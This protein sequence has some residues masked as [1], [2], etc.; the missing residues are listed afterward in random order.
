MV[1]HEVPAFLAV[2]ENPGTQEPGD[3]V[4]NPAEWRS[5]FPIM[6]RTEKRDDFLCDT[7]SPFPLTRSGVQIDANGITFPGLYAPISQW[8]FSGKAFDFSAME[9]FL[10][11]TRSISIASGVK[12]LIR[13]DPKSLDQLVRS[14]QWYPMT[15]ADRVSYEYDLFR[16]RYR[17][18][19][20]IVRYENEGTWLSLAFK[21]FK[22]EIILD[23]AIMRRFLDRKK[24]YT[25]KPLLDLVVHPTG[26]AHMSNRPLSA[27]L[28]SGQQA[29]LQMDIGPEIIPDNDVK[30]QLEEC[31]AWYGLVTHQSRKVLKSPKF[32]EDV[33][34]YSTEENAAC[35]QH[36]VCTYG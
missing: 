24:W 21:E 18:D 16:V 28:I 11:Y 34:P 2:M 6:Y 33:V 13:E 4:F 14:G 3:D 10:P 23:D 31:M 19:P 30:W 1:Y 26:F 25:V 8:C 12:S 29:P 7:M 9:R 22:R 32:R 27:G 17:L 20:F 36:Y 5:P 15:P 35:E